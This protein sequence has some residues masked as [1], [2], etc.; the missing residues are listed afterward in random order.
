MKNRKSVWFT[1]CFSILISVSSLAE[2]RIVGGELATLDQ[3]PFIVSLQFKGY[4]YCG[5]ALIAPRWVLTAAHCIEAR[6]PDS[7]FLQQTDLNNDADSEQI[8]VEETFFHPLHQWG[9]LSY[10]FAL[11]KLAEDSTAQTVALGEVS[12]TTLLGAPMTVVGWGDI[13]EGGAS[14]DLL[15]IVEVPIVD[16]LTCQEQLRPF[17]SIGAPLTV[18]ETMFCAGV[19]E[20]G[21]DACQGDSGGPIFFNDPIYGFQLMGVVSWGIGCAREN[22]SGVYGEIGSARL[23]IEGAITASQ[24]H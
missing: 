24:D 3:A 12:S 23:W 6:E 4:H 16:R 20:G 13:T 22:L 5:G 2:F 15:Q 21:R 11:V 10:D 19:I 14:S 9:S 1:L 7:V 8:E 17:E 18:D